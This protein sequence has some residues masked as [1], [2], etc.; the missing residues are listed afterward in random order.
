MRFKKTHRLDFPQTKKYCS[1]G[2]VESL[3]KE[4]NFFSG[5]IFVYSIFHIMIFENPDFADFQFRIQ[6]ILFHHKNVH[7]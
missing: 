1:D 6:A 5:R 7:H 2:L 4:L 3:E